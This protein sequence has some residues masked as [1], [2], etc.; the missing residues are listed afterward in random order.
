MYKL[1]EEHL[2]AIINDNT[3]SMTP[4]LAGYW[5]GVNLCELDNTY[6]ENFV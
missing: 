5:N 1:A 3:H 2:A 4:T 6:R